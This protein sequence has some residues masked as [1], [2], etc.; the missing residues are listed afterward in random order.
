M[1]AEIYEEVR[2]YL[3]MGWEWRIIAKVINRRFGTSYGAGTLREAYN[4]ERARR[5]EINLAEKLSR[6]WPCPDEG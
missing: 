6:I 5:E 3:A 1:Q 2:L 4:Q